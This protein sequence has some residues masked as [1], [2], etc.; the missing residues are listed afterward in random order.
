GGEA[1]SVF[2]SGL[3]GNFHDKYSLNQEQGASA[4]ASYFFLDKDKLGLSYL[5]GE[6]NQYKRNTFGPWG[7]ISLT[8]KLYAESEFDYQ[9]KI[10]KIAPS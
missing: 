8:D 7:I 2:V 6:S 4:T 1:W 3:L 10:S 9:V 5:H